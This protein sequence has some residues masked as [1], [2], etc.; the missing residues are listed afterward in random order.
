MIS[1][2]MPTSIGLDGDLLRRA[3]TA[4]TTNG[5]SLNDFII[6]ALRIALSRRFSADR[7]PELP[8]YIGRGLQPGVDLDDSKGLRDLG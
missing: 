4:A 7:V 5:Q 2:G 1:C 6:D 8:T 3:E